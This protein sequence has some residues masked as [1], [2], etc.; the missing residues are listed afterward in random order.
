MRLLPPK[1]IVKATM[2]LKSIASS[3]FDMPKKRKR[4]LEVTNSFL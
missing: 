1:E 4:V 3:L 2:A